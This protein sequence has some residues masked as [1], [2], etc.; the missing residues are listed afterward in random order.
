MDQGNVV[1]L[2]VII[3]P[4]IS[5][6]C[7][8]VSLT[9]PVPSPPYPSHPQKPSLPPILPIFPVILPIREK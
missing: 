4:R 9:Y 5:V 8:T 3:I 6:I 2:S 7:V 1:V